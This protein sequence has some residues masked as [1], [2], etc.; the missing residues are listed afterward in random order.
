MSARLCAAGLA[1]LL[2]VLAGGAALHAAS[3]GTGPAASAPTALS[4]GQDI[5][6][7]HGPIAV[8]RARPLWP[9]FIGAA[10]VSGIA[11]G[12]ILRKRR[13]RPPISPTE[14][15]LRALVEAGAMH[16]GARGF[17]FAVSEIV[18]RYVEESFAVRA[19]HL[20][21]EELL[22]DLMRDTSPVAAHR[23]L[24]GQ[25]LYYCDLAKYAGW[26]LSRTEME[27]MLASSEAFV[28]ATSTPEPASST[29]PSAASLRPSAQ[30]VS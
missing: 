13:R 11:A 23:D 12:F 20:T 30:G 14:R 28:R 22:A 29:V 26:S 18:R 1:L 6:D 3:L 4:A 10:V 2:I 25:F 19:A 17:A 5:R 8:P 7:I 9:Y 27:A 15:A 16:T 21:T 24:L